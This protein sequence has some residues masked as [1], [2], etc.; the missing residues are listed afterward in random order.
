MKELLEQWCTDDPRYSGV[1]ISSPFSRGKYSYA[2]DGHALIRVDRIADIPER[3]DVPDIKGCISDHDTLGGWVDVPSYDVDPLY[4]C[5]ACKGSKKA[6]LCPICLGEGGFEAT[7]K[8]CGNC[9]T[10]GYLPSKG[11]ACPLCK[12]TGIRLGVPIYVARNKVNMIYLEQVKRLPGIKFSDR[13]NKGEPF[14]F[15]FDGGCGLIMPM[16]D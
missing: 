13:G 8:D 6:I 14:R 12:G 5:H 1:D 11:F 2:T 10:V 4:H 3:D 7:G 16:R 15:K 9:K